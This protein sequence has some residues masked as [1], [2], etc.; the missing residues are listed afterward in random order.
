MVRRRRIVGLR[1]NFVFIETAGIISLGSHIDDRSSCFVSDSPLGGHSL[2][3]AVVRQSLLPL[4]RRGN[5]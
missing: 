1:M 2:S 3:G 4:C 5:L